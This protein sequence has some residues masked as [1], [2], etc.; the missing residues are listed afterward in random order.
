VPRLPIR[1]QDTSSLVS[2]Q[3]EAPENAPAGRA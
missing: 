2:S 3:K 1:V